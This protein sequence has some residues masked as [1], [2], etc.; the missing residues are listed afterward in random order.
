MIGSDGG[1]I[2]GSTDG[3]LLGYELG[4]SDGITLKLGE[5]TELSSLDGCFDGSN[6]GIPEDPLLE[7]SL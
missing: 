5:E 3:G 6:D 1:I 7:D 2:L 4:T